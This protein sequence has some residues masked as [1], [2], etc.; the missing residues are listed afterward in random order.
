M[1]LKTSDFA[2][3][4]G[5]PSVVKTKILHDKELNPYIFSVGFGSNYNSSVIIGG[6]SKTDT[7]SP[8][9]LQKLIQKL[10]EA[11]VNGKDFKGININEILKVRGVWIIPRL[12]LCEEKSSA[13]N[14][15]SSKMCPDK[16]LEISDSN[17]G[18]RLST[19]GNYSV[20]SRIQAY[21]LAVSS[22][23]NI[24][25]KKPISENSICKWYSSSFAKSC[26]TMGLKGLSEKALSDNQITD[27][28][29]ESLLLYIIS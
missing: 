8:S 22:G 20:N 28:I 16:M 7:V 1:L 5:I 9:I 14:L 21:L 25:V 6:A 27:K 15:I 13:L 26:Y 18:I 12:S 3:V 4:T 23:I 29:I 10:Q 19:G 2:S 17:S 11:T 24:D